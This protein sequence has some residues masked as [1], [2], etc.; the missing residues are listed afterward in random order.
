MARYGKVTRGFKLS[1][2][3]VCKLGTIAHNTDFSPRDFA[4]YTG[5]PSYTLA[6]LVKRGIVKRTS[7]GRYYPTAKGWNVIE[8]SCRIKHGSRR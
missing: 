8:R 1:L 4:E 5:A 3:T 6:A 7:P 2:G